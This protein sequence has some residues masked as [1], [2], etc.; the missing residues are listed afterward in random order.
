MVSL[1]EMH[2]ASDCLHLFYFDYF[3]FLAQQR[4]K[5]K[6]PVG[7]RINPEVRKDDPEVRKPL[8]SSLVLAC[9][10]WGHAC[11]GT[12]GCEDEGEAG[13]EGLRARMLAACSC[14]AVNIP[15]PPERGA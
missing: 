6:P 14:S 5:D 7:I 15:N 3:C 1:K 11:A 9:A 4:G 10:G 13:D 2:A 8:P 12:A